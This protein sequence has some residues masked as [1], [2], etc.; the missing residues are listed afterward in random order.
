[1]SYELAL[2]SIE[3]SFRLLFLLNMKRLIDITN[4]HFCELYDA[5]K[6]ECGEAVCHQIISEMNRIVEDNEP[7]TEKVVKST[8]ERYNYAYSDLRYSRV[9]VKGR[10]QSVFCVK[11]HERIFIKCLSVALITINKDKMNE[12][13]IRHMSL[14]AQ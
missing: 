12:Q 10:S 14:D 8:L 1:M 5:I 4:H 7:F 6:K 2:F 3:Q 13:K 11:P 9:D